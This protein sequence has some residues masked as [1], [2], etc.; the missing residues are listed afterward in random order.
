MNIKISHLDPHRLEKLPFHDPAGKELSGQ[1][2][3]AYDVVR[4]DIIQYFFQFAGIKVFYGLAQEGE[5]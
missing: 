2:M 5:R 4:C 1:E 3:S